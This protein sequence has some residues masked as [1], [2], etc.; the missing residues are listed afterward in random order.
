MT[1][2]GLWPSNTLNLAVDAQS[3]DLFRSAVH[4]RSVVGPKLYVFSPGNALPMPLP[5]PNLLLLGDTRR[6]EFETVVGFINAHGPGNRARTAFDVAHLRQVVERDGWFP[7]LVVVLQSWPDQ[8]SEDDFHELLTIC[9]LARIVCCYGPWCDSDGRTR[10]IWPLAVRV[11]AVA[12]TGRLAQELEFLENRPSVARP[13]PLTASRAEIF[14]FDF[15]ALKPGDAKTQTALV[16]SP[17][18]RFRE[19]LE[20]A[21]RKG[22]LHVAGERDK[23]AADVV[24]FDADPWN[25]ERAHAFRSVRST[26][27]DA[28]LLACAGFLRPELDAALRQAGAADVW[29]KLA[30]LETLLDLIQSQP[31]AGCN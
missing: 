19:M 17:D 26:H 23:G 7:D 20:S 27:A 18:R 13:L 10:A 2:F 21:L 4:L 28:K 16:V 31:F 29:F 6:R 3:A 15:R 5:R 8:F 9:P 14:E 22:G 30:P 11:P 25:A 24:V 12:A 1:F